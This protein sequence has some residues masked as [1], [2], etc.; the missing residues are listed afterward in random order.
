MRLENTILC[1]RIQCIKRQN[2]FGE[3][4]LFRATNHSRRVMIQYSSSSR[5]RGQSIHRRD[6][7]KRFA[8]ETRN[9][10]R[11]KG[12]TAVFFMVLVSFTCTLETVKPFA[13]RSL[14]KQYRGCVALF[15]DKRI[16]CGFLTKCNSFIL[17]IFLISTFF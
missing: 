17:F 15:F 4:K 3:W 14:Q 12:S 5:E 11:R 6:P 10:K 13:T 16:R 7:K 2:T 9:S 1:K 8:F